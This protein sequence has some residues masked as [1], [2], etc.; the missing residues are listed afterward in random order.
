MDTDE[1]LSQ[2]FDEPYDLEGAV[3]AAEQ[4]ILP[5]KSKGVYDK[6]YLTYKTWQKDRKLPQ[7]TEKVLLAYF[8]SYLVGVMKYK[9]P[10]LWNNYSKLKTMLNAYENIDI[11]PFRKLQGFLKKMGQGYEAKKAK[12]FTQK[13]LETFFNTAPDEAWL[14]VKV[15]TH[16]NK[17]K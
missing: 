11:Q 2:F 13:Q 4:K 7:T 16:Y 1:D 6:A 3:A 5:T 10:T 15:K 17:L 14:D 12:V 9:P 8:D